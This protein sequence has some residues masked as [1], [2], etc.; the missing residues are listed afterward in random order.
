MD[1]LPAP[2]RIGA[3]DPGCVAHGR[4]LFDPRRVLCSQSLGLID[5]ANTLSGENL[6][7]VPSVVFNAV[8]LADARHL[9]LF[10]TRR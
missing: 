7:D 4:F 1:V 5:H 2:Q 3:L 8:S 6:L 10:A 9:L